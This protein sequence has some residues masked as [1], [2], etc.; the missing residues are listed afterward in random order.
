MNMIRWQAALEAALRKWL[1]RSPFARVAPEASSS[2]RRAAVT[3][4]RSEWVGPIGRIA[5][6]AQPEQDLKMHLC[7]CSVCSVVRRCTPD[8]DFYVERE[9]GPLI[10]HDCFFRRVLLGRAGQP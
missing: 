5:T 9:R 7:R 4:P 10:C 6:H 8:F 3:A 1:G 2:A